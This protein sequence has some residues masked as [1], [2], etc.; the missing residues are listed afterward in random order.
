MS[1]TAN[2]I[3]L[4]MTWMI[5]IDEAG[6]GPNLGP[7]VV[8]A[9][10]W[11][12]VESSEFRIQGSGNSDKRFATLLAPTATSIA[13]RID[14]YSRL[15]PFIS[16][17]PADNRIAIADSKRLYKP[18]QGLQLLE[19][20]VLA[21]LAAV[22][23]GCPNRWERLLDMTAA[24]PH[25]RRHA[26]PWYADFSLALPLHARR[27]E[28]GEVAAVFRRGCETASVQ[29]RDVRARL[30]F[31]REFNELTEHYGTKGAALSHVSIGLLREVMKRLG[32]SGGG[33]STRP[34]T[35]AGSTQVTCDKHGGRNRYG[36]L[37]QHHFP[38]D[39]IETLHESRP[40]SQY[41]WG[42]PEARVEICF[43]TKGEAELPTAL[44]SMTAKYHRELAMRAFNEYWQHYLPGVKPTAGYP[45]DAKRFKA[46]IEALQCQL[47]IDDADLWRNR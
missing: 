4:R 34:S 42:P 19:R 39:W 23:E 3:L 13:P 46:D 38:D 32:E 40:A 14:L 16:Q 43:R 2:A 10:V 7:L 25:G 47:E 37:L 6:Y 41:R 35:Q 18:G 33:A 12:V 8:A 45:V 26:L 17:H 31:P 44:A 21:A 9:T 5:G 1:A 27:A 24:D 28:I 20:G 11:H 36:A 15:A 22:G 30:V 29:L